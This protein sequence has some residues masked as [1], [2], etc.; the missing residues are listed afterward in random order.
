[1]ESRAAVSKAAIGPAASRSWKSGKIR[2]ATVRM[3]G[4]EGK[5]TFQPKPMAFRILASTIAEGS[6][7]SECHLVIVFALFPGPTQLDFTGPHQVL[8]RVPARR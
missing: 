6:A 3:S 5:L 2:M 8:S 1:M 4:N 7:M